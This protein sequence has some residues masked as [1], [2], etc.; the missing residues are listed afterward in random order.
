MKH[1]LY[2]SI[3]LFSLTA[4]GQRY[5][6][7]IDQQIVESGMKNTWV[8]P[9]GETVYGYTN[10]SDSIHYADGWRIEVVPEWN[11]ATQRIDTLYYN[12]GMDYVTRQVID[13]TAEEL[14]QRA[15]AELDAKDSQWDEQ[16]VKRLLQKTI[17]KT[18]NFDS[19]TTQQ[20]RD[21]TTIYSHYRPNFQPYKAGD[22]IVV[23]D[24]LLYQV[25]Q[26][27]TSQPDWDPTVEE[28]LYVIF[29]PSG[30]VAEWR[31][32][33]GVPLGDGKYDAYMIGDRV[34]FNGSI[35][36]S[37]IDINTWSPTQYPAGWKLIE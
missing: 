11:P 3:L 4:S 25:I 19:L 2:I 12:V 17:E 1:I 13:L 15:E 8:R 26:P 5:H 6:R 21:L 22:I 36:E 31:Q 20:Y 9:G 34:L 37:V 18:V 16:A 35:Y 32:R 24:T 28:S 23:Q 14:A 7:V 30:V 10:L 29:T 27:H 33:T